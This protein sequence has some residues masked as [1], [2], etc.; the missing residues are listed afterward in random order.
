MLKKQSAI[1]A[2]VA[3]YDEGRKQVLAERPELF[4]KLL[5]NRARKMALKLAGISL[6]EGFTIAWATPEGWGKGSSGYR[7]GNA[8]QMQP[9]NDQ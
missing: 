6:P 2:M 7:G 8:H 4:G 5:D 3:N 9:E 1:A